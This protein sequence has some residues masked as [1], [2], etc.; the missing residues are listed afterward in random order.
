MERMTREEYLQK[1]AEHD[2]AMHQSKVMEQND[3]RNINIHYDDKLRDLEHQFRKNRDALL[4][5]RDAKREEAAARRKN[6]RRRIWSE[7]C[8]LVCAWRAQ[9]NPEIT[10]PHYRW[11]A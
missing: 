7:D 8:E 1:R 10:P 11:A 5:E 4:A 6:E 3:I 9:L 2:E